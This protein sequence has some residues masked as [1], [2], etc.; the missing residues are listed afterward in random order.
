MQLLEY[1][2]TKRN[3]S[4]II[5][6]ASN[7]PYYQCFFSYFP[8]PINN[9]KLKL[10]INSWTHTLTLSLHQVNEVTS[11]MYSRPFKRAS[12]SS[13]NDDNEFA[14]L[15]I[16]RTILATAHQLPGILRW[17][18]V[19]GTDVFE[20]SPLEN[21]I[22]TMQNINR[23]LRNLLQEHI[24]SNSPV[25]LKPLSMKLNGIIDAA[26]MGGTAMYEKAFFSDDFRGSNPDLRE[27]LVV[28]ENLMAE[29]IPLL[30]VGIRV[31]D[32]KKPE[33]L[34]PLHERLTIMFR[35]MKD[36]VESKYGQRALGPEFRFRNPRRHSLSR[37]STTGSTWTSATR[38][39]TRPSVDGREKSDG[40][41]ATPVTKS[42]SNLMA[43]FKVTCN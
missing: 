25:P 5:F 32:E 36:H 40:E 22:E 29:Q 28:L 6:D 41:S 23:D 10:I 31:H 34:K 24:L 38:T 30:E 33:E 42:K 8:L 18:P 14:T 17:F 4:N 26:V 35:Q 27:S 2:Q 13:D 15:W 16:E 37:G 12:V 39:E 20:L 3:R 11:F 9:Y 21:A 19:I 43:N 7:Y 1:C